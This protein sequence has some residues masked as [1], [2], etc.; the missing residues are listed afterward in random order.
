MQNCFLMPSRLKIHVILVLDRL[1]CVA[2]VN[3]LVCIIVYHASIMV[4]KECVNQGC[5]TCGVK[6]ATMMTF[7][8]SQDTEVGNGCLICCRN[9]SKSD[10]FAIIC[11]KCYGH[12]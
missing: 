6:D 11:W 4:N 9:M 10:G 12:E 8:L 2:R 1:K 5:I 3:C 7:F